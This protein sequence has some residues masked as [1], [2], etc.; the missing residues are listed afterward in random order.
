MAESLKEDKMATDSKLP[1]ITDLEPVAVV[2]EEPRHP[3]LS[4]FQTCSVVV[5]SVGG[6]AIFVAMSTMIRSTGSV[7]ML[8]I[9]ILVSGFINYSLAK[10]FTEV[11]ICLPK[12]GGPYFFILDVFGELPAFLF[13]WGFI[14]LII[15]PVWAFLSYA[16]SLYIVQLFFPGCRPPDLAVK[17]LAIWILVSVVLLNSLYMQYVTKVQSLLTST[18][19]LASI[20]IIICGVISA[21]EGNVENYKTLF[22]GSKTD[23]GDIAVSILSGMFLFGGWQLI[24]FLLEEMESPVKNLP[25]TLNIS[26]TIVILLSE[27]TA[28]AYFTLI[29]PREMLTADAVA[30]LFT[31]RV[32]KPV[33]PVIAV[34]VATTSISGLNA[35][36]MAQSRLVSAGAKRRHLPVIL[37]TISDK[38][39]MPWA[40]SFCL[41]CLAIV[42]VL[43]GNLSD[44]IIMTSFYGTVMALCVLLC[45]FALRI[46]RPNLHRPVT[47]WLGTAI[48]QTVIT[49][50]T[51]V[52]SISN[53]PQF[54]GLLV[55]FMLC[56]I[57]VY[58]V[59]I[60]WKSKP[61]VIDRVM[62]KLTV[63][64][65]K[66]LVLKR[67]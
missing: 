62:D 9:I 2:I 38:Y 65:Q 58:A 64:L 40:T 57:P 48:F 11:A 23:P 60:Y 44:I 67:T 28:A 15:A 52:L 6:A 39:G 29:T 1:D 37:S 7:G 35:A 43:V 31:E 30:V 53:R 14:F 27:L 41:C 45:F 13:L 8:L 18:K 24:T 51:L 25:R 56:G 17:I 36:I 3:K 19:V 20:F 34:F 50:M 16:S 22:E 21:A 59:F 42:V 61:R 33:A 12:A 5:S 46:R 32:Y 26:F 49:S 54:I 4:L 55:L 10:C 47:A 66:V 63:L